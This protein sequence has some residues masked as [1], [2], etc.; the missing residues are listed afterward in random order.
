[1]VKSDAVITCYTRWNYLLKADI[2]VEGER[3]SGIADRRDCV[4]QAGRGRTGD[5]LHCVHARVVT[6]LGGKI[7]LI[8]NKV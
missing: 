5:E 4:L 8:K 6:H 1:M 3:L 2:Q 7:R